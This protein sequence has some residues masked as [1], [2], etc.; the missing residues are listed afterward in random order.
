ML[1]VTLRRNALLPLPCSGRTQCSELNVL[2][3]MAH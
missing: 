1:M 3:K 2:T